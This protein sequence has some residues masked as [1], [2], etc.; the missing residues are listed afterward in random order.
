MMT[1]LKQEELP[2]GIH[3]PSEYLITYE[4][5]SEF[6]TLYQVSRANA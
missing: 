4:V 2:G 3:F 6:G 1:Y 5:E